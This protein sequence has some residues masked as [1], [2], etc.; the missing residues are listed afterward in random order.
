M[1]E[2][3]AGLAARALR[4]DF[5]GLDRW[6]YD[7]QGGCWACGGSELIICSYES[8]FGAS[9]TRPTYPRPSGPHQAASRSLY[10]SSFLTMAL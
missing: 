1:A 7:E 6:D 5:G 10:T 4:I 9:A 8:S 3:Q 2:L